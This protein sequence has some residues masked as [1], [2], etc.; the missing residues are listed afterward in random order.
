[1]ASTVARYQMASAAASAQTVAAFAG[2]TSPLTAPG[3]FAG[4]SSQGFP[5]TEPIVATIDR[6][7]PAPLEPLPDNWWGD[8]EK[9]MASVEQLIVSEIQDAGRT[10]SQVEMVTRPEWQNY[11]RMLNPPSCA[12][13]AILAGR[14]YRDLD[15]FDRHPGCDCVMVP[16]QD[17]QAAHDRAYS[18][19]PTRR[20]RRA[21]SADCPRPTQQGHHGRR[22]HH[23]RSSTPDRASPAPAAA[24]PASRPTCSATA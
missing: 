19:R 18:P 8:A 24:L 6:F 12:R 14:I 22:R 21:R 5:I 13:C 9:F 15:A 4:V 10:A 7:E 16:V 17:W 2:D 3:A 23:D 1:V 11:V 20:S